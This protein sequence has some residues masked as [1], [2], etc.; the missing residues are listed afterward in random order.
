M[1]KY[2]LISNTGAAMAII[3]ILFLPFVGCGGQNLTGIDVIK[4]NG[5]GIE[6]KFFV[7]A[8]I[9]CAGI[10]FALKEHIQLAVS[11]IAGV[12]S[13]LIAFLIAQSKME[14]LELKFGAFLALIAYSV[15][16]VINFLGIS[17]QN[18]NTNK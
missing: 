2:K 12:V 1:N 16:A 5:I 11:A 9:I 14:G 17:E 6:I 10:I 15:I 3:C 8:S 13:L 7:V 18:K 4:H